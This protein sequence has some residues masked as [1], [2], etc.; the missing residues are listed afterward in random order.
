M[1]LA[2]AG[3]IG[4]P[5]KMELLLDVPFWSALSFVLVPKEERSHFPKSQMQVPRIPENYLLVLGNA[6]PSH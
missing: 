3:K 2:E 6:H 1:K 4:F 5:S